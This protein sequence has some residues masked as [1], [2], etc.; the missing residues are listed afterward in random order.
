[1]ND[2]IREA[3]KKARQDKGLSREDV[4]ELI[5]VPRS[6]LEKWENGRR[7]PPEYVIRMYLL[8]LENLESK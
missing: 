5:G 6:T 2:E 3:I 4:T 7:T 8:A 1:M